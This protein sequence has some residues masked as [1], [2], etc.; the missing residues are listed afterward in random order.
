[1]LP[2]S[3]GRRLLNILL[4]KSNGNNDNNDK[5]PTSDW[6]MQP[7]GISAFRDSWAEGS[8]HCH[9]IWAAS[10]PVGF[11]VGALQMSEMQPAEILASPEDLDSLTP[12]GLPKWQ[13][14]SHWL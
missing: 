3:L 7:R 11:C 13:M 2:L 8:Q 1:M 4:G 9:Q 12:V 10:S 14:E 5:S 6:L